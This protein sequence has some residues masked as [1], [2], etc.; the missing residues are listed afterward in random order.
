[1]VSNEE[2]LDN[3]SP[4]TPMAFLES[5]NAFQEIR[6][7]GETLSEGKQIPIT[8]AGSLQGYTITEYLKPLS[9]WVTIDD[10]VSPLKKAYENLSH[11]ALAQGA[12]A[13]VSL[14]ILIVGQRAIVSAVPVFVRR[15]GA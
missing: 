13:I 11:Q 12:N 5:R 1:M 6:D 8:C 14:Q 10:E 9:F 7:F 15:E 3:P 2:D 4:P